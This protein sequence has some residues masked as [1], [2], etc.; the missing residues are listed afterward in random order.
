MLYSLSKAL[1]D[2]LFEEYVTHLDV[3]YADISRDRHHDHMEIVDLYS[4]HSGREYLAKI[5]K[6]LGFEVVGKG[7]ITEEHKRFIWMREVG[8][9]DLL[10]DQTLP[11]IVLSDF[12]YSKMSPAVKAILE[13]YASYADAFDMQ[14]LRA[15]LDSGVNIEQCSALLIR[16]VI[17]RAWPLPTLEEFETVNR[18]NKLAAWVLALG[19][20]VSHFGISMHLDSTFDSLEHFNQ[21]LDHNTAI[22]GG[23]HVLTGG[24]NYGIAELSTM[25]KMISMPLADGMLQIGDSFMKFVWR[26]PRVENKTQIAGDYYMDFIS[27]KGADNVQSLYD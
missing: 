23:A 6:F 27:H 1:L 19:R 18:E 24:E 12:D 3:F 22:Q 20:R 11:Q 5:F 4:A 17:R 21:M 2:T 26:Y 7:V 15:Y 25:G 10:P 13:K 14:A 9:A 8:Y 16:H